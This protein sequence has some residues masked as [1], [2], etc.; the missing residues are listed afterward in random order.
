MTMTVINFPPRTYHIPE[1]RG[2][3]DTTWGAAVVAHCGT[4]LA[5]MSTYRAWPRQCA[6]APTAA[7]C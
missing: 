2:N 1:K 4:T 7:Q 3:I 6:L 5:E